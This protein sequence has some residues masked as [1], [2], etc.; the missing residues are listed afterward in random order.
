METREVCLVDAF[1]DEPMAGNPAGVVPDAGGLTEGQMRAV[2]AELG[3]SETAFVLPSERADRRLRYFTPETEVDLCGHA[4]VATFALLAERD[5]A[6]GGSTVETGAGVVDVEV[7]DDGRVWTGQDGASIRGVDLTHAEVA[8]A[9]GVDPAALEDVGADLPMARAS[10]GTPFL[11]VPV[12]FLEHLGNAEPDMAAVAGLTDRVDA[13]GVYA[14]TFDTL[15]AASTLH[16]RAFA[17]AIGVPEDPVTGTASGAAA[18]Y[19]RHHDT[20]EESEMVFEQGHFLD[21]PGRVFV[22]TGDGIAVGGRA[23]TTLEGQLLVPDAGE[24]EI[25]EV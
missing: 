6:A 8:E 24:D 2:A 21:R 9:L 4:T 15:D 18:A 1:A 11:V 22:R 10:T 14:F 5:L 23:V 3:A 20:V 13:V 19:L 12:N 17:P 16:A 7:A 25:I